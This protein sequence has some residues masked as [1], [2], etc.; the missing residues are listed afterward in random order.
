MDFYLILFQ[1]I[2]YAAFSLVVFVGL[3]LMII[4]AFYLIKIVHHAENIVAHA[5]YATNEVKDGIHEVANVIKHLP[6]LSY[7]FNG[8]KNRSGKKNSKKN[9][10]SKK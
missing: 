2:F 9:T 1:T 8:E 7:F 4:I 10:G 5:R 3:F 6:F